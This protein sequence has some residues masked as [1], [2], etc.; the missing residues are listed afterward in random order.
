[1]KKI[2][3]IGDCHFKHDNKLETDM[4]HS[5]II[6]ILKNDNFDFVVILGD[7]LHK[8]EKIDMFPL[9]RAIKFLKDIKNVSNKLYLLIGNHDRPN[10]ND[11]LTDKHPFNSLKEWDKTKIVDEVVVEDGFCFVPY[12]PVGRFMEAIKD[13]ELSNIRCV[14]SH[15]EY[16]GCKINNLIKSDADKWEEYYPLNI[17]GHIHDFE[18]V[19][20]NL[21]YIGTP[22]QHSFSDSSDKSI[23]IFSFSPSSSSSLI[24]IEKEKEKE[25]ENIT[26]KR[27]YLNIQKK[28]ELVLTIEEF[29][30]F[31]PSDSRSSSKE[32]EQDIESERENIKYKIKLCGRSNEIKVTLSLKNID[33]MI[34]KYGLI[35]IPVSN[36]LSIDNN[37]LTI[38]DIELYQKMKLKDKIYS[39]INSNVNLIEIF[40]QIKK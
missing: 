27:I 33:E 20:K 21:I 35:I 28:I 17:S 9:D 10:N 24:E 18:I 22:F 30:K 13:V 2:C 36:D 25:N 38:S 14:F 34:K 31:S 8:H 3:V 19:Q 26:H 16:S 4:M 23:S 12:V 15:Q 40:K 37:K 29:L 11:F 6:N 32:E 1:M 5:Q 7:T 39:K